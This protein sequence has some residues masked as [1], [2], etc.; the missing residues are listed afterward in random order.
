L[1]AGFSE[2]SQAGA[3]IEHKIVDIISGVNGCLIGPNCIGFLNPVYNGVFTTPIPQLNSKGIDFISGSGATAV[4]IMESAL[5]KGLSFASVYSVGNSAQIGVEEVLQYLDETH[6]EN[7]SS[8]VKLL[9][10][11]NI[12][13]PALFLK[14]ARSLIL[15]GCKIAAIK[16]GSS[17]AG[18]RAA[19]SHT[20]ALASADVA[21]DALMKKAGI[22]RCYG[23]EE[24]AVVA[25]IFMQ[26]ELLGKNIAVVT[27]AGGPGVMLTDALSNGGLLVPNLNPEKAAP[28]LASLFPGSSVANPIDFL[29]TGTAA[30]LDQILDY[31]ENT[32]D[33]IDGIA[34][35]FG[36][37]GL[38]KVFDVFDVLDKRIASGKKPIY[39][40][41]PSISETAAEINHFQQKGRQS[42]PDEVIFGQALA[43]VYFTKKPQETENENFQINKAKIRSVIDGNDNG[44]LYPECVQTLMDAVGIQR[45]G[46]GVAKNTKEAVEIA[47][48]IGF[49]VVMKVVGPVHKSDVGGV[50]LHVSE[51]ETVKYEFE[52]MMRI[53]ETYAVLI[54]PMLSG[55]ELFAGIKRDDNFGHLLMC[56]LGGIFIEV[57]KDVSTM[58]TPVNKDQALQMIHA[59]KSY[60]II[61]GVRGKS[62]VNEQLFA[63]ILARLSILVTI[64]PEIY[65]MDINPLLGTDEMVIAVDARI[66]IER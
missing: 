30:Q 61:V 34:V 37:P 13:K 10:I 25:G 18:S 54:Q 51:T 50:V 42:F 56:G 59:L 27:H 36:S 32:F 8:K 49:P 29:A 7:T 15:K 20:G 64:A 14:H 26:N 58:L 9:Y 2:E 4:F 62:G 28:L 11:E 1:S 44:Y 41:L 48:R 24:L 47:G 5:P 55:T 17:E 22:V 38:F 60:K 31:C 6:N 46:E 21:V 66:R 43:K 33:E 19:S 52:R 63:D 3:E 12:K 65:E 40:V 57:L 23:R 53:P 16:S 45:A 35:I 39:P